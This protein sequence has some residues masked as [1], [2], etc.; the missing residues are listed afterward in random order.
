LEYSK[1]YEIF[2][3][4]LFSFILL[5]FSG[6]TEFGMIAGNGNGLIFLFNTETGEVWSCRT[7][8]CNKV[9]IDIKDLKDKL[10]TLGYSE[11]PI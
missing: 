6:K 4:I 9:T 1:I 11:K 7:S 10:K 3:L 8:T 2:L 5:S